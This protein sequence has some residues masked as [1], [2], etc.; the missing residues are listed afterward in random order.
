MSYNDPIKR[1]YLIT[2][3]SGF[4]ASLLLGILFFNLDIFPESEFKPID[5]RMDEPIV[6]DVPPTRIVEKV[7]APDR[8]RNL[9]LPPEPVILEDHTEIDIPELIIDIF[10]A[11]PKSNGS[12]KIPH[13]DHIFIAVEIMPEISGGLAAL[14]NEL[15]YP[16]RAIQ[17]GLQG[18][19]RVGFLIERDGTVHEITVVNGVH[20]L[21]DDEAVRAI[22]MMRFSPGIQG[23]MPVRVRMNQD[24]IFRLN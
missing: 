9:M 13:D 12:D 8:P 1:N 3:Q 14:Y 22:G 5:T 24:V 15:K 2:L 19:V 17:M 21:L 18:T 7:P 4:I 23:G 6:Y 16:R 20:P 11:P 10:D